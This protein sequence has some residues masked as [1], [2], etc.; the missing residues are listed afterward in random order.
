[1]PIFRSIL[2]T[3]SVPSAADRSR[4]PLIFLLLVC[5]VMC[6]VTYRSVLEEVQLVLVDGVGPPDILGRLAKLAFAAH[7]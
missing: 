1:M 2:R 6:I 7:L 4:G 3:F 5:D